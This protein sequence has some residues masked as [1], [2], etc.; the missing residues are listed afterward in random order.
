[1]LRGYLG[2]TAAPDSEEV[3][4]SCDN[5]NREDLKDLVHL[6]KELRADIEHLKHVNDAHEQDRTMVKNYIDEGKRDI[7]ELSAEQQ[8]EHQ[9]AHSLQ[10]EMEFIQSSVTKRM[11]WL[12]GWNRRDERGTHY[13]MAAAERDD[14]LD[15]MQRRFYSWWGHRVRFVEVSHGYPNNKDGASK[16]VAPRSLVTFETTADLAKFEMMTKEFR[17]WGELPN[18]RYADVYITTDRFLSRKERRTRVPGMA[19]VE[20]LKQER[21][22]KYKGN[23]EKLRYSCYQAAVDFERHYWVTPDYAFIYKQNGAQPLAWVDFNDNA[24]PCSIANCYMSRGLFQVFKAHWREGLQKLLDTFYRTYSN[25]APEDSGDV[26]ILQTR[27]PKPQ[28]IMMRGGDLSENLIRRA[29]LNC[30]YSVEGEYR[31]E[32]QKTVLGYYQH[33]KYPHLFQFI[34]AD[35][36]G[37]QHETR[38]AVNH[39]SVQETASKRTRYR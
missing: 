8:H 6:H 25:T 15:R 36:G 28:M 34:L 3:D 14:V 37:R 33:S 12:N 9:L 17:R 31:N 16:R 19:I 24:E 35:Q 22:C 4:W 38:R 23:R 30:F 11:L 29:R 10:V 21:W 27:G 26:D 39:V 32:H 2:M 1:M 18:S 20:T 7:Q 5:L 13:L